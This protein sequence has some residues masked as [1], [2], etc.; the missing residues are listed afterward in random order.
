MSKF[1]FE[2]KR[3]GLERA[4]TEAAGKKKGLFTFEGRQYYPDDT[5]NRKMAEVLAPLRANVQEAYTM[6]DQATAEAERLESLHYNDPLATVCNGTLQRMALLAPFVKE[7]L[8][9]M[10]NTALAQRLR[11]VLVGGDEALKRLYLRYAPINRE[12]FGWQPVVD[13]R[14]RLAESLAGPEAKTQAVEKEYAAELRRQ[15][16]DLRMVASNTL[17]EVDGSKVAADERRRREVAG[18][19]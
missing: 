4:A 9:E 19:F 18:Y 10:H 6:A 8:A 15:A 12:A 16:I 7:E 17:A 11:G 1:D 14:D 5:H 2:G 3:R 13:L